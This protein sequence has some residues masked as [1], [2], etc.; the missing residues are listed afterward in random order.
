MHLADAGKVVVNVRVFVS[1][2]PLSLNAVR[3]VRAFPLYLISL[4]LELLCIRC[5]IHTIAQAGR[6]NDRAGD[7]VEKPEKPVFH[8]SRRRDTDFILKPQ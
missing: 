2:D 4:E 1:P 5:L 7:I 8:A 3:I 6:F